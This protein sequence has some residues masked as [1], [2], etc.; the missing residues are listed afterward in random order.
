MAETA[1]FYI[2]P[3]NLSRALSGIPVTFENISGDTPV[4]NFDI[5]S[6]TGLLMK[7][8]RASYEVTINSIT[9]KINP[10]GQTINSGQQLNLVEAAMATT[11]GTSQSMTRGAG[12]GLV[13]PGN[14]SNLEPRDEF[15]LAA[16][17]TMMGNIAHAESVNDSTI[18]LCARAA[19]R[20]AQGMMIAA[21]DAHAG[22]SSDGGGSSS[23]DVDVT[24][25]TNSEKLLNNI[26]ASLDKM[27][28]KLG[29]LGGTIEA[30]RDIPFFDEPIPIQATI[31]QQK[32][33]RLEFTSHM[34]YSN[35]S[36]YLQLAVKEGEINSTRRIGYIIPR[37]TVVTII[38]NLDE[39]VT[40]ITS[41]TAVSVRGKGLY[42]EN[43][44]NITAV[45]P[46]P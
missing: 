14:V 44:Y 16:L 13:D 24:G 3:F 43:T 27:T 23:V 11:Y 20:W 25:G 1:Q 8:D 22:S 35:I 36:I 42:D 38:E 34:A 15:A 46:T 37:G 4:V 12:D 29:D 6:K 45:N 28:E 7:V 39:A 21:A 17:Q 2:K 10:E 30:K 40:E 26:V 9:Y 31:F 33:I 18:L 19:Y 32:C 41:I 5:F